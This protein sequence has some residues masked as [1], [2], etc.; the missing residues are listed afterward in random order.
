[1]IARASSV[2][3]GRPLK[4]KASAR[5][6]VG[7]AKGV[8]VRKLVLS[9]VRDGLVLRLVENAKARTKAKPNVRA[10]R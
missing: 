2:L 6:S 4:N 10:A 8:V 9:R 1:M 7:A 3:A 5:T